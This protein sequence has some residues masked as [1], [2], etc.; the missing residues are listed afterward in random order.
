MGVARR[1]VTQHGS[2]NRLVAV[3]QVVAVHHRQVDVAQL[4][5]KTEFAKKLTDFAGVV[6]CPAFVVV[7]AGRQ[8]VI[9]VLA[10]P[11]SLRIGTHAAKRASSDFDVATAELKTAFCIQ[12]QSATQGVQTV[13]RIRARNERDVGDG[14]LRNQIP[15]HHVA[16]RFVH[17]HPIHE[18][19][20]ALRRSQHRR[21]GKTS[22]VQVGLIRVALGVV[23]VDRADAFVEH[24][25]QGA[26]ILGQ[27]F[28]VDGL[29]IAS[30]LFEG[31]ACRAQGAG[32]NH[33]DIWQFAQLGGV[34]NF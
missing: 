19:G 27:V 13:Y 7:Y 25:G 31:N 15:R 5:L 12:A 21:S 17:A 24:I 23:D 11:P 32:A 26:G 2:R 1:C 28:V 8:I 22:V 6:L 16:K 18:D 29:H 3:Q 33:D 34:W 4:I 14:D 20:N 10:V 30:K 9:C